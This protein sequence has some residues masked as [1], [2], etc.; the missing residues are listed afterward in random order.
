M[1]SNISVIQ[2]HCVRVKGQSQQVQSVWSAVMCVVFLY[3]GQNLYS[4]GLHQIGVCASAVWSPQFCEYRHHQPAYS[5]HTYTLSG[6]CGQHVFCC[7]GNCRGTLFRAL[8]MRSSY[9][10]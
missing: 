9:G 6:G 10:Q 1:S 4:V 7:Y 8:V 5:E 2:P 3:A